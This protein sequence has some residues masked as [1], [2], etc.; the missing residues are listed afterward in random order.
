MLLQLFIYTV[1]RVSI[2]YEYCAHESYARRMNCAC[3]AL[4]LTHNHIVVSPK[5]MLSIA[6]LGHGGLANFIVFWPVTNR[7]YTTRFYLENI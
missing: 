7:K 1:Q 3:F 4:G 6:E 2:L 5:C